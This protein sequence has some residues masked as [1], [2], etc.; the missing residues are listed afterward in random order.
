[1]TADRDDGQG[2]P[3]GQFRYPL[4]LWYYGRGAIAGHSI[5]ENDVGPWEDQAGEGAG[6]AHGDAFLSL[7]IPPLF[8]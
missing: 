4:S 1:V 6:V 7:F 2:E 8:F 5:Y 3:Q